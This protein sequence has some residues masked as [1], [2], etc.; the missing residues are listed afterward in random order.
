MRTVK[1]EKT[2]VCR[3]VEPNKAK[4]DALKRE[5]DK[6][7]RY[8]NGED[9]DIYSATVQA[10]DKYMDWGHLKDDKEYPWYLRNDTFTVEK[11]ENTTEFD[12]WAK[13]PVKD[14]TVASG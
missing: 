13:I 14:V 10:M 5:Y 12:Y 6:V 4:L 7:Q 2:I 9:V 3:V 11:G 8:I 1:A